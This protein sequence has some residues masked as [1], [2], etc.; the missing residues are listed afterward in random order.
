MSTSRELDGDVVVLV[1]HPMRGSRTG[2]V[3]RVVASGL[4]SDSELPAVVDLGAFGAAGVASGVDGVD[5]AVELVGR[6]DL[7]VVATPVYTAGYTGLLKLFLERL[8]A[9][10][11]DGTVAVPVVL[12]A[13]PAHAA[14]ADLQLR[15]VLE[16]VGAH[17]PVPSFVLEEHHFDH[18]PGYVDAWQRRFGAVVTAVTRAVA[19]QAAGTS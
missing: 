12:S 16:A 8:D 3:A 5:R 18:L 11:L 7:L 1:G 2:E 19:L 10:A 17:L 9:T 15:M 6:A 14:L 4:V 13:S